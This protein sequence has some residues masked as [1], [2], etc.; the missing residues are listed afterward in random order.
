MIYGNSKKDELDLNLLKKWQ[1]EV[2]QKFEILEAEIR[3]LKSELKILES[4]KD[5]RT[6]IRK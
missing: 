6:V 2:M 4:R 5:S 3:Q 1:E